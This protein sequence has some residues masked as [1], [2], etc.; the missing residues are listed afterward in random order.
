MSR[1]DDIDAIKALDKSNMLGSIRDLPDQIETAW[2]QAKKLTLPSN[3]I[4]AK[5]IVLLGMGGSGEGNDFA[6]ALATSESEVPITVVKDYTLPHFVDK[7]T[8]LIAV[9]YSGTTEEA[10]SAVESAGKKGAKIITVSTGADLETLGTRYRAPHFTISYGAEPRAAFGYTFAPQ[11]SV[12]AR[13]G[14]V[15][16][17]DSDIDHAV[18]AMRDLQKIISPEL[19]TAK[20]P[21]K[22]LASRI[23]GK[24]P[25]AMGAGTLT[26]A[27]RRFKGMI[28]ENAKTLGFNEI[29]PEWDHIGLTG[30]KYPEAKRSLFYVVYQSKFDHQR[31]A[32]RLSLAISTLAKNGFANEVIKFPKA[33]TALEEQLLCVQFGDFVSY[34]L[35]LALGIDPTPTEAIGEL[36]KELKK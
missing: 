2:K 1:L 5:N 24:I 15:D 17:K 30:L 23:L 25:I 6:A 27:A 22:G 33:K 18:A 8:L 10:L 21:A 34:Y 31:N 12:F 13:I 16:V 32:L 36:K 26:P 9:S 20:N 14:L 3:Y 4:R 7:E 35:A 28:N 19:P 11:L 29:I